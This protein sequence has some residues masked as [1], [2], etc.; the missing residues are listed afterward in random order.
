MHASKPPDDVKGFYNRFKTELPLS[1]EEEE[2]KR[3]A[4]E[5]EGKKPKKKEAKKEAKKKKGKK[6]DGDDDK[7][8]IVKIGPSEVVQKFDEF[9]EDYNN[10]WANRDESENPQ[11]QY[12]QQMI[13]EEVMPEVYE[14]L[15]KEVDDCIKTELEN[16]KLIAGIKSKK[17]KGKKKKKKGKKQKGLKLPGLSKE[18]KLKKPHELMSALV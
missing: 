13:I 9:Y 15:K 14:E 6:D 11:Q 10:V 18:L 2:A 4:E 7:K 1:P 12:D 17:K 8:S 16:M 5:E 3:L